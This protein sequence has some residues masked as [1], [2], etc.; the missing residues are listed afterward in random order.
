MTP[1][2]QKVFEKVCLLLEADATLKK[3]GFRVEK[4]QR[5]G[6]QLRS[7]CPIHKDEVIRTL[8]IDLS[9]KTFRCSY[10]QCPGNKGGNLIDL[11]M[12]SRKTSLGGSVVS[13]TLGPLRASRNLS[14]PAGTV[15]TEW[16]S[17]E[18]HYRSFTPWDTNFRVFAR[19]EELVVT[20]PPCCGGETVLVPEGPGL[21]RLGEGS[22][23]WLRFDTV[24]GGM[25]Q[26]ALL[27]GVPYTRVAR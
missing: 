2:A 25:A 17:A 22:P 13:L 26:R 9:R 15:P 23:E 3:I 10:G 7:F 8:T 21:F 20:A 12:L 14:G 19:G 4:V 1:Q 6:T 24:I 18:G 27:S 16:R 5:F 11:F